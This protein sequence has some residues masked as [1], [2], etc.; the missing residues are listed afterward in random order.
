MADQHSMW[1]QSTH[2]ADSACLEVRTS[3]GTVIVRNSAHHD[4]ELTLDT[5]QWH[6]LLA[7]IKAGELDL[8]KL[9]TPAEN[10]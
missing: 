8:A 1:Q 6:D 4:S 9:A 2:C 5:G 10:G 3:A 7:G